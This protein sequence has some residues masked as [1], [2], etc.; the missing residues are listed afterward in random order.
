MAATH[1]PAGTSHRP[2]APARPVPP[3]G[4]RGVAR[5][6]DATIV[7]VAAMALGAVA[8][9]GA[10]WVVVVLVVVAAYFVGFDLT[11]ATPGKRLVGLVVVGPD[12]DRPSLR[13]CAIREAFV[14]VGAIPFL[15]PVLLA[16]ACAVIA[17]TSATSPT[18]QGIHDLLAG[19]TR[20]TTRGAES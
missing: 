1:D 15:G 17:R 19:G 10:A 20:V 5:A 4:R 12:G 13:S 7:A 14:V 9:F 18:G 16:I 2:L 8:G 11:G 6:V 3:L